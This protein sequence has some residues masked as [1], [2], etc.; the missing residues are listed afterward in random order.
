MLTELKKKIAEEQTVKK[1]ISIEEMRHE[2]QLVDRKI[3]EI[4][5]DL[6]IRRFRGEEIDEEYERDCE[7]RIRKLKQDFNIW[8]SEVRKKEKAYE[9][10]KYD[11]A[12]RYMLSVTCDDEDDYIPLAITPD[13]PIE[14]PDNS[15]NMGDEHLDTIPAT[16]SDEVIKSSVENLVPIPSEFEGIS[17]D[18]CDVPN[19]DN[20]RVN[21]ESEL[22]ESLINRDTSIDNSSKIDLIFEEFAG[23]LAH[24]API[25]PGIVEADPD[26][27]T[28]SDDDDFEDVEYVS[29]EE[30]NDVEQ[31][32]KEFDLEDIL[33]IQ[34]VI[35]RER[36]LKISRL[37]TNI[38]SL[39]DNP[40]PVTDSDSSDISLSY[41]NNSLPEFESFSDDTEET[42]SGST[43]THANYSLPEFESFH[44]DPSFSRPPPEP[45][46]VEICLQFEPDAPVIDN[47]NELN[48]DQREV[49]D[50]K[51]RT[52]IKTKP[53][54]TNGN[55]YSRKGAKRK[56]K[57]NKSKHGKERTKS[58][59]SLNPI[60]NEGV[61]E[62]TV[63]VVRER[64]HTLKLFTLRSFDIIREEERWNILVYSKI[65]LRSGYHQLRIREEDIPITA[66]LTRYDHY[67]IILDKFVIVFVDDILIYS[68]KKEE[69]EEHLK[70]ILHLL[71]EE[72]LYP[73]FSKCDFWLD[74]VQF[75]GHVIDSKG[76]H[77]DPAK[78][79]AIKNWAAPSTPTEVRQFL[80]LAGYYWRFIEE[81]EERFQ[82]VKAGNYVCAP[83]LALPNGTED[84]VMYCDAS[85]K[86]F[87]AV[88]MQREKVA[89]STPTEVRQF[90]GLA[91]YYR[92]FIEGFSL[93]AKPFTKLTQK[94]KK[95]EWDEEE[96]E[97][98][99]MLKE[100]LC[101][102]PILAMPDGTKDFV[103]YCDVSLK[104]YEEV[105]M[106]REKVIAYASWHYLYGTKCVVYTDHKSLQY[107]LNQ[108]ELNMRQRRW[109]KLL[110]DYDCEI[111]YHPGKPNVVAD[112]LNRKEREPLRTKAMKKENVEAENLGR[113]IKP[114]F[115][116][117]SDGKYCPR[118]EVQKM[119]D[120]FYH[121]TMK[122][123]D[124]KTYVRRFQELATLCPTMV[125]DSEKMMEVFIGGLP[126]SI[127]GNVIASKPQTL[128]EAINIAR[129]LMDHV[130]KHTSVQVSSDHKQKFDDKRTFNNYPNDN[131]N[132]YRNTNTNNCYNNHQLQQNKRQETFR[133]YA[134]TPTENNR[135]KGPTTGS[136]LLPVT[137]TCH[138][139]GEKGHYANQCRK[140]T[141]NNAQGRAYMLRDRNAHQNPN[142]VMGM[143]LLNQ[144][145]ARVLFDSGADKSFGAILTLLNQ[146]FKIDLM[147][148]KLGSFDVVIGMDWLSKYHAR[149]ICDEKVVH[150]PIDGETLIIRG[151]TP[152][153]RAPYRL[154]PSEMQELS[155]QLQELADRGFIRPS[156]S[157][158]GALIRI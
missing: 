30:V 40:I 85:L 104:G 120:E 27:D 73:K 70:I 119:E 7:I 87:G 154:A 129:R 79:E 44:F 106:Q 50:I 34:D 113:L 53:G 63:R 57:T 151:V 54:K 83:I 78:T 19:C 47:F 36:L 137:V 145:L 110:S 91:G 144:H 89:P 134:V 125:P 123:N 6:G 128:E 96:E 142:V 84:F 153:A 75:L 66:F 108:K 25:P 99:Q 69:H 18:T 124:L 22:V 2:Q 59:R 146:P 103:V 61:V 148:I 105:L 107:I 150:I 9:D 111:R 141:N 64:F 130:T 109:I 90:L 117:R 135:N 28:S 24:I 102:A 33:Q 5:N 76:I 39:K 82:N 114:I 65:D 31:E 81:E 48:D 41:S 92:R 17:D 143:F 16:E 60:R 115:K 42:R 67:E 74:S 52:K 97:A 1:N 158:W 45:P 139:C 118:T 132:N 122:G 93:I 126:R 4:T 58:S 10:E 49:P 136:N 13:L 21:V 155:N 149:I 95:Y 156:T 35:L 29:F 62:T 112:A 98:F 138:A 116:I 157:P 46:D 140:T 101:S 55:R 51:K 72:K 94:K 32:E 37:I 3:K 152:V 88:L 133:A 14:E 131:N 100:K 43:T 23:E 26:D 12:C 15:L 86:E 121:L 56:P 77:V 38:E 20:N 147:P 71:K 68:K 11:A 8:G 80:G 127:E